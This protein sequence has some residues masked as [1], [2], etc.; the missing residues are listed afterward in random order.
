MKTDWTITVMNPK[1]RRVTTERILG[2][3]ENLAEYVRTMAES[4]WLIISINNTFVE[5]K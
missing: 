2:T 5:L 3:E 1:T 4:E